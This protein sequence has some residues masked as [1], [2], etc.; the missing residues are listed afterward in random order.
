MF[1][2]SEQANRQAQIFVQALKKVHGK[3]QWLM[4]WKVGARLQRKL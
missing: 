1:G 3:A 2:A 4:S